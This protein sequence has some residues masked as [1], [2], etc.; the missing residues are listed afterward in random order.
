MQALERHG[1][2]AGTYLALARIARCRPGCAGGHDPVPDRP[3]R[4]PRFLT[5]LLHSFSN[6]R[7]GPPSK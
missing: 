6:W 4:A 5:K 2:A 7:S 1:A 3:L